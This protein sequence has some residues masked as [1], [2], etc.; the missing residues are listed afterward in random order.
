[1][2]LFITLGSLCSLLGVGFGAFGAHGLKAKVSPE[3]LATWN[4]G[5]LY[6]LIHALG[7][8]LLGILCHLLPGVPLVK[9]AG[10]FLLAGIILF[11]GSLYVLVLS[12][13]RALGMVTPLGGISFLIGW[14]LLAV[15]AWQHAS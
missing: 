3:M 10:W 6:H 15:A 2:K 8:I 7:L 1:M 11:S 9:T 12:D 14:A 4:T 5:V 13:I